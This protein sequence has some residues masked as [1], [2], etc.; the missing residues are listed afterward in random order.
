MRWWRIEPC[1]C[2]ILL[3][4][5]TGCPVSQPPPS[6][7]ETVSLQLQASNGKSWPVR[8]DIG[9]EGERVTLRVNIRVIPLE[10][11][12][13]GEIDRHLPL[14]KQAIET[15]WGHSFALDA[16]NG[17]RYPLRVEV[18]FTPQ[19]PHYEVLIHGAHAHT[20]MLNW[21]ITDKPDAVAHEF[22]HMLGAFDEYVGG[23]SDPNNRTVDVESIMSGEQRKGQPE[24]RHLAQVAKWLSEKLGQD[25][26]PLKVD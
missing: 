4:L 17:S 10:G 12:T 1:P 22:G 18:D 24:A 21:N 14:W 25:V 8:F 26:R 5:G 2:I 16:Y 19:H 23:M 7:L 6:S 11:V 3:L 20:D 13:H 9:L 15:H